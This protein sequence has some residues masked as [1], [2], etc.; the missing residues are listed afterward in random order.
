MEKKGLNTTEYIKIIKESPEKKKG[1]AFAIVTVV[2]AI[3]LVILASFF[4]SAFISLF[5]NLAM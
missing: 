3:A 2:V 5:A 1:Y 4:S